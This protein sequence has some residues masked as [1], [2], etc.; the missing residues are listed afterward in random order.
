MEYVAS[1]LAEVTSWLAARDIPSLD[2][3][4]GMLSRERL[5]TTDVFGR[6]NYMEILRGYLPPLACSPSLRAKALGAAGSEP[7]CH[8]D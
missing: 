1:L 6:A 4:L 7:N 8:D 2:D 3:V 5:G